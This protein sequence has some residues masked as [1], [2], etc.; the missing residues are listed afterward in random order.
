MITS[1]LPHE[2]TREAEAAR[3]LREKTGYGAITTLQRW[4]RV[5]EISSRFEWKK[6]SRAVF[7]R[8]IEN[9]TAPSG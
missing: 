2:W 1:I 8:E 3:V 9:E 7:W 5:N 4:R 6:I